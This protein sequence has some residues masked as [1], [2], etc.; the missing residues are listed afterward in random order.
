VRKPC[1]F[2]T[3]QWLPEGPYFVKKLTESH[4]AGF[5]HR[6][7]GLLIPAVPLRL[8]SS[9]H[10]KNPA[11]MNQHQLSPLRANLGHQLT[12]SRKLI[13]FGYSLV[14]SVDL[15]A[16]RKDLIFLALADKCFVSTGA[17]QVLCEKGFVDDGL[18]LVR[19]L[20]EA[21]INAGYILGIRRLAKYLDFTNYR[22]LSEIA[23]F[24]QLFLGVVPS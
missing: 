12:A 2:H 14:F 18:A 7:S 3:F 5:R 19:V 11:S 21:V 15:E 22:V 17:I 24:C 6:V 9:M 10:D 8:S 23:C 16:K 20:I 4:R 1:D 13:D